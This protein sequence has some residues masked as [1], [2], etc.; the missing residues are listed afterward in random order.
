MEWRDGRRAALRL[1]RMLAHLTS[2]G[3][4]PAGS[5]WSARLSKVVPGASFNPAFGG[6]PL[7]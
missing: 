7:E 5:P 1:R 4:T 6:R 3:S 2:P